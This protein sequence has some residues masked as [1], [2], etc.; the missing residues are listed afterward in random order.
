[1]AGY[2]YLAIDSNG[3]EKRG[4][5]EAPNEERVFRV[6]KSDGLFPVSIKEQNIFNRDINI[7][8]GRSIK[9]RD[10]SV[11]ARQFV[12]I[13]SAGVPIIKALEMIVDQTE[14]KSLKKGLQEVKTLV[15]KGEKLADAMRSQGK[16][17]PPILI[18]M[19]EAGEASGSL[20][21][22][23]ERMATHFEK[24]AKLK[25]LVKKAMIYPIA[26]GCVSLAVVVLMLVVVI[27]AFM[28]MFQ[29]MNMKLPA[30][31]RFAIT[32]SNFMVT[33]WYIIVGVFALIAFLIITF[34][35]S[36]R[37]KIFFAKLSLKL[38]VFGKITIK[39]ASARFSRTLSTLIAAGI[40]LI[41]AIEITARTMD[42]LI[43]KKVL[44]EAKEE[45]ERGVPLSVPL[46]ASKVFP[47]MV[48]HMT[49]IGEETGNIESML[50]K[51]ADYYDEEVEISTQSMT[52]AMEPMII[53]ILALVVGL[54]I[55]AIMQPMF[56]MYDQ[57]DTLAQ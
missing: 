20:E 33:R 38:P 21:I 22:A 28:R 44:L 3:R 4:R 43:I 17:F 10:Y 41:D 32:L 34:K 23:L 56:A 54:L 12:S 1:M 47:P 49:R 39:S 6:L 5:M 27:P 11:F 53:I 13:L 9:A 35:R 55:M 24:E 42:N 37:G 30:I 8:F 14:N 45:V 46:T 26:V 31:T 25:S 51:I 50:T 7:S 40:P 29:D 36:Y 48:Y 52:A 19:V 2:I 16:T 57:L 18:N 15:E